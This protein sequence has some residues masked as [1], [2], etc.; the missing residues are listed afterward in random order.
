MLGSMAQLIH[1][2]L[3]KDHRKALTRNI[4]MDHVFEIVRWD[5][6]AS[7]GNGIIT[8]QLVSK[9]CSVV[10]LR[11]SNCAMRHLIYCRPRRL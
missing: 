5:P 11:L 6:Y 1:E 9:R 4:N 8:I 2:R 7:V 3:S 10:S